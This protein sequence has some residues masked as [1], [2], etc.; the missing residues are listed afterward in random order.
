LSG[1]LD[2]TTADGVLR[3]AHPRRG[4]SGTSPGAACSRV[5]AIDERC[6]R[7]RPHITSGVPSQRASV[8]TSLA[9]GRH[10]RT[11]SEGGAPTGL[12]VLWAGRGSSRS[13]QHSLPVPCRAHP[14]AV[15]RW[16]LGTSTQS[17]WVLVPTR[18]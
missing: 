15:A 18:V 17:R 5:S 11:R 9:W 16:L 10:A 1:E 12:R 2:T 8:Q 3:N 14:K 6:R 7:Q 4:R 13:S